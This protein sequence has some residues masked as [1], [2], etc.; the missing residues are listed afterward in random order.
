M[1]ATALINEIVA[2]PLSIT[3]GCVALI[4]AIGKTTAAVAQ[5]IVTCREARGDVASISRELN[6]L[7]VVLQVLKDDT[8]VEDGDEEILASKVLQTQI[9]AILR[10]YMTTVSELDQLLLRH[11]GATGKARWASQGKSA[12]KNIKSDTAA[13]KDIVTEMQSG[14]SDIRNDTIHIPELRDETVCG[15]AEGSVLEHDDRDFLSSLPI[16]EPKEDSV[17]KPGDQSDPAKRRAAFARPTKTGAL[18]S[19]A[20]GQSQ[21]SGVDSVLQEML[22]QNEPADRSPA[23]KPGPQSDLEKEIP[24][25]QPSAAR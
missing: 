10:N 19:F 20:D 17:A 23:G 4:S 2:D 3:T 24:L 8:N 13:P 5:F 16:P 22:I 11:G 18:G 14:A 6:G 15:D 1:S 25:F 7:S 9:Q 21:V 12:A